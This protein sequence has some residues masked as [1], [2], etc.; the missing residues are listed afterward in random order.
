M[1]QRACS[2]RQLMVAG[3]FSQVVGSYTTLGPA[4]FRSTVTLRNGV[5]VVL[6]DAF[7]PPGRDVEADK[8]IA[9]NSR[10]LGI[11]QGSVRSSSCTALLLPSC[12][13]AAF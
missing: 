10:L 5:P 6:V 8:V 4:S 13:E 7:W 3:R 1:P 12:D 11:E 2:A 9:Q